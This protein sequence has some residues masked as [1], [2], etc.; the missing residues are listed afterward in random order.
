M[1]FAEWDRIINL[2]IEW[3]VSVRKIEFWYFILLS[4]LSN[5]FLLRNIVKRI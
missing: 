5:S 4:E 2:L 1:F 3:M